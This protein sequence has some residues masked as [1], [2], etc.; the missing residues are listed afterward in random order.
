M[1]VPTYWTG[2]QIQPGDWVRVYSSRFGV[3]H[4]VRRLLFVP[5]GI[6]DEENLTV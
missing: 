1:Q 5:G 3:R 4:H 2:Q 6:A